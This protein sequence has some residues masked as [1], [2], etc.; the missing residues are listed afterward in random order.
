[1]TQTPF[2]SQLD[3]LYVSGTAKLYDK[4]GKLLYKGKTT[5][6]EAGPMWFEDQSPGREGTVFFIGEELQEGGWGY[7]LPTSPGE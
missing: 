3:Q 6:G 1:M 7:D 2:S 4:K 5:F